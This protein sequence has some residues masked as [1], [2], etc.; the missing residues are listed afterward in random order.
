MLYIY[1]C[2]AVGHG[3]YQLLSLL[4]VVTAPELVTVM[5]RRAGIPEDLP[6]MGI[7]QWI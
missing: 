5:Q 1:N 3:W 2:F 4:K 6:S 7:F